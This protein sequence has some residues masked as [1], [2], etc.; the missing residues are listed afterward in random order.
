MKHNTLYFLVKQFQDNINLARFKSR[1]RKNNSHNLTVPINIFPA[2][3]VTVGKYTYGN[4]ECY[5]YGTK[6]DNEF[7]RIGNSCSIAG[8]TKFIAGGE[9]K[10]NVLT[11]FPYIQKYVDKKQ[12]SAYTKGPIIIED[13]V[14]IG[15][16]CT[17]LSGVI[18]GKGS[19]IGAGSVVTKDVPPYAVVAGSPAKVIKYRFTKDVIEQLM[20]VEYSTF[21][22]N[23]IKNNIELLS[24]PIDENSMDEI[25]YAIKNVTIQKD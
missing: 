3:K 8:N 4:L 17:I 25:I 11:T 7:I 14:W 19:V 2:N 10:F 12:Y 22:L 23:E 16:G 5:F 13:D 9:H 15:R 24:M 20:N 6:N 18:L 1:W 21:G